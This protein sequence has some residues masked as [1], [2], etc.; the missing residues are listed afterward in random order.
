MLT[1]SDGE[2]EY[3]E[4]LLTVPNP[5]TK[6]L[7]IR[8]IVRWLVPDPM[9]RDNGEDA[10]KKLYTRGEIGPLCEFVEKQVFPAFSWRDRRWVNELTVK[11][12]FLSLLFNE[13]NYLMA[14]ERETRSGY[15]DL[16]MIVRPDRRKYR[17]LD[18]LIEFKFI[19]PKE[20]KLAKEQLREK[21]DQ[22]LLKLDKIRKKVESAK[23]QAARY[24]ADLRAEFGDFISLKTFTVIAVG[25]ERIL[26]EPV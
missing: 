15:A 17:L 25:F 16:A 10:A 6:H 20:L 7:Y 9:I 4:T 8:G 19:R 14:S 2:S 5:V 11:T 21:T 23:E 3:G 26:W 18:I 24:S 12:M 1:L 13:V 22:E